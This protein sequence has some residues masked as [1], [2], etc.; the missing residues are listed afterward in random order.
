MS[1]SNGRATVIS[2]TLAER[3]ATELAGLVE[4]PAFESGLPPDEVLLEVIQQ[5]RLRRKRLRRGP[6]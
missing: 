2:D 6:C 4:T 5:A 1:A 3:V